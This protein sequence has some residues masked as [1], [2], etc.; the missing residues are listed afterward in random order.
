MTLSKLKIFFFT[1]TFGILTIVNAQSNK[2]KILSKIHTLRS[3]NNF[4]KNDTLY[5]NLINQLS[6]NLKFENHDSVL[7]LTNEAV[8]LSKKNNYKKGEAR[9]YLNYGISDLFIGNYES[10]K[11]KFNSTLVLS[12][13][14]GDENLLLETYNAM[15]SAEIYLNNQEEAIQ[16]YLK[17][18]ELSKEANDEVNEFKLTVNIATLFSSVG[19]NNVAIDYFEKALELAQKENN[20]FKIGLTKINLGYF[21]T[22]RGDNDMA[23]DYLNDGIEQIINKNNKRLLA[24]AY[25]TKGNIFVNKKLPNKALEFYKLSEAL[26]NKIKAKND[27]VDLLLGYA[28]THL[29]LNN[30]E[31]AKKYANEGVAIAK[32]TNYQTKLALLHDI[33]YEIYK[34]EN[35]LSLAL[36]HIENSKK[37]I[38]ENSLNDKKIAIA[39]THAKSNFENEQKELISKSNEALSRQRTYIILSLSAL[40]IMII[41]AFYIYKVNKMIRVL[42]KKLKEKTLVLEANEAKLKNTKQAQEKLFS[43]ISHDLKSPINGLK[44]LLL[45]LKN[46]DIGADEFLPFAPKLYNDVDAMSFSLNNLLSWS[47]S[48]MN[49][50]I[51]TPV[52]FNLKNTIQE[53]ILF[54]KENANQ[55][56]IS[57]ENLSA[58][59]IQAVYDKNQFNLVTRNLLNNAIKFTKPEGKIVIN[60]I[61]TDTNWKI[62]IKDNGVGMTDEV[63]NKIFSSEKSFT[64]TYGTANEKGTGIGLSLCKEML[65]NNKG[66]IWAESIVGE[67]STF[68]F[69]IPKV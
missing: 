8:L 64:T 48:Q 24:Y 44:S 5:I 36:F 56:N 34:S 41:I 33:L 37:I 52:S 54:L 40:L 61:E 26:L 14:I 57:I 51:Y 29:Q 19:E 7:L 3:Q 32:N 66:D 28:N 46:G 35:N 63:K 55:K 45:M 58:E 62:S 67:G 18:L 17:A 13:E 65:E 59:N 30:L 16:I 15:G 23:L 25:N 42:N 69:T 43:I 1:L 22:E 4:T 12:K 27:K 53:T 50:F 60:A 38:K 9:A 20:P 2:S 6:Y 31:K 47:K 68:Y 21:Y 49:G 10:A 11:T 39:L